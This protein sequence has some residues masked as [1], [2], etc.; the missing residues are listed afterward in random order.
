MCCGGC[1]S[2]GEGGTAEVPWPAAFCLPPVCPSLPIN[3]VLHLTFL[4]CR[5]RSAFCPHHTSVMSKCP[6]G[7]G[8]D[9]SNDPE[10]AGQQSSAFGRPYASPSKPPSSRVPPVRP[11]RGSKPLYYHTYLGLD[12]LLSCQKPRVSRACPTGPPWMLRFLPQCSSGLIEI[13]RSSQ[14]C[15]SRRPGRRSS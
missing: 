15:S 10:D 6:L 11:R 7:F 1:V 8:A 9:S 4:S 13:C 3:H 2:F 14:E 12:Q 5:T